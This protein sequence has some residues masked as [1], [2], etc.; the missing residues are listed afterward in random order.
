MERFFY[1]SVLARYFSERYL[2]ED[3]VPEGRRR[4]NT[5]VVAI[6]AFS[7]DI[8]FSKLFLEQA[9]VHVYRRNSNENSSASPSS[10]RLYVL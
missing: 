4:P 5:F 8:G 3:L 10:R 7:S 6:R 9:A 1:D 2:P